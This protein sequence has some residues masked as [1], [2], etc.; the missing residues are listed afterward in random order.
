MHYGAFAFSRNNMPTIQTIDGEQIGQRNGLSAGDIAAVRVL[1][2]RIEA[3]TGRVTMLRTH[4]VGTRYGP[5]WD[6]IDVEVVFQ[7]NSQGNRGFGFQLRDD[8]NGAAHKTM[9]DLLR[10]AFERNSL[11]TVDFVSEFSNAEGRGFDPVWGG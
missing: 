9:L 8:A 6:E 1:Y 5:R 10:S 7:L 3:A 2:P 4:D 11:V